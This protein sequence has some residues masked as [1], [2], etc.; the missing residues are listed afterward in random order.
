MKNLETIKWENKKLIL[1]DQTILPEKTEYVTCSCMEDVFRAINIMQVRGA[2]AIGVAAAYGVVLAALT[3]KDDGFWEEFI[4]AAGHLKTARP[5]AVNLMWA[6]DRML[7]KATEVRDLPL[8]KVRDALEQEAVVIHEEDKEINRNIGLHAL[9]L[10]K[11]G[12]TVLTHCNAGKLATSDYGTALSPFYLAK[13]MGKNI[14]VY[15]DETR[16]RLQGAQLTSL[17]LSRAGVDVTLICDNMAAVVMS[18][19]KID[20]VIVG[21]DRI[22]ANGDTANKVGTF[23]VSILAK[24]FNIPMYIAAPTPTIDLNCPDGSGIP[25]EERPDHEIKVIKGQLI[26]PEEVK[27]YNPAF[28]VTPAANITA[29]ITEKGVVYPPFKENLKKLF[30]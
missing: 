3:A 25:I 15:A 5:T 24:Y 17:E 16:P 19:G 12:A 21:C 27:V 22:A 14:K 1:L 7:A 4:A 10:L 2:P 18:Q 11:D 23:N 9:E 8:T 6:V 20:A 29:I 13:E 30:E 26:A 28:D